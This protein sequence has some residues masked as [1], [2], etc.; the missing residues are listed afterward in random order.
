M[1]N[2]TKLARLTIETYLLHGTPPALPAYV[3]PELLQQRACYVTI[4]ENPGQIIR[5]MSGSPLPT[6]PTLAE[7]IISHTLAAIRAPLRRADLPNLLF[8]VGVVSQLQRISDASHLDPQQFG[9]YVRTEQGHTAVVMPQRLG[10]ETGDDQIA[11]ALRE[12]NINP[13]HLTPTLYRFRVTWYD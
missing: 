2:P 12:A 6:H 8:T 3:A 13:R 1:T 4:L 9:L 5:G 11:T 10:V 7:E